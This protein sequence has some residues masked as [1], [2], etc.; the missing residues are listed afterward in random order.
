MDTYLA[1][2]SCLD[3]LRNK[4]ATK[5]FN[6]EPYPNCYFKIKYTDIEGKKYR[7]KYVCKVESLLLDDYTFTFMKK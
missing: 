1:L 2:L 3:Y 4:D 7:A 5:V 6:F